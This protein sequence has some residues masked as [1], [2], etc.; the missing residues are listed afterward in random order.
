MNKK[1]VE[2]SLWA[3][4]LKER[5]GERLYNIVQAIKHPGQTWNNMPDH[6]QSMVALGVG[7]TGVGL[8]FVGGL[9]L[10]NSN[11][12]YSTL[13][14]GAGDGVIV[15]DSGL[16]KTLATRA[17]HAELIFEA[18]VL[19]TAVGAALSVEEARRN[20]PARRQAE[21]V[22]EIRRE[23]LRGP[24]PKRVSSDGEASRDTSAVI[25]PRTIS[26]VNGPALDIKDHQQPDSSVLLLITR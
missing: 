11:D 26:R 18:G 16:C 21:Y 4:S 7:V 24:Y 8:A 2:A 13:C 20:G 14:T 22:E 1:I 15:V 12:A 10:R 3:N 19:T 6:K 17:E 23:V 9:S 5:A 25:A